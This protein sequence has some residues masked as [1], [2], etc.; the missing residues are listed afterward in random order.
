M[1]TTHTTCPIC[2]AGLV[3]V[4]EVTHR[5]C[6]VTL[7]FTMGFG[8]ELAEDGPDVQTIREETIFCDNGHTA[9]DMEKRLADNYDPSD[10]DMDRARES[11]E[12]ADMAYRASL[13]DAGRY[14][15]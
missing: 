14:K 6:P 4:R 8:L 12:H 10:A 1:A 13:K 15:G 5:L 11:A 9:T 7:E 2:G 3:V